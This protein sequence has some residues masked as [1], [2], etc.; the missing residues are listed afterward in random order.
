MRTNQQNRRQTPQQAASLPESGAKREGPAAFFR[1]LGPGLITGAADD[2]PSGIATYSQAGAAFGYGLLWTALVSLPLMVG[3]QLM[4]ARLGVVSK[5]GL[6]TSLR[7]NYSKTLLWFACTLLLLANTLNIA[8]DLGG[9]AASAALLSGIPRIVLVPVF[10]VII[11]GL[12]VFASYEAMTRVFKWFAMALFAYVIAAFLAHP[13]LAGVLKGTL[14]PSIHLTKDYLLTFVA[15]LGT[16]ISPY[17]FF[18][19]ASQVAEQEHHIRTRFPLRRRRSELRRTGRELQDTTLDTESGMFI[20]Q[21]IMF[22]II[23]TAGATLHKAG[24]TDVLSAD[25]AALA[26][27]PLAGPLAYWLFAVGI[28][29]TGM[30][31]VPVL[32]GSAAYA[33]A[34]AGA[35]RGGMDEKPH[36]ARVFYGVMAVSMIIGML[37][38]LTKFNA[39]KMLLWSAV[40][41]GVLAPPLIVI[42]L[43]VCNNTKIMGKYKNGVV[44]NVLGWIAALLMGAAAIA[45]FASFFM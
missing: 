42:I 27:R 13:N 4:C 37:L 33:I 18:W 29:G 39:M 9:M 7:E 15:L 32:A 38:A 44:L 19:Q 1:K 25:Q 5:S 24:I 20:S 14:Y 31:G 30:L 26:L 35:F 17:L 21:L 22:F 36:G 40:L 6:A 12:L 16:T 43:V 8:A 34:E 41:N 23:L 10:A 11:L 28:I 3:V 2:D 45:M